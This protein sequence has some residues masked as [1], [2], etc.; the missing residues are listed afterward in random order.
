[1]RSRTERRGAGL[2]QARWGLREG[3]E[4]APTLTLDAGSPPC[5]A[6]AL[7]VLSPPLRVAAGA[8][9]AGSGASAAYHS[10]RGQQRGV[11]VA[12]SAAYHR[13]GAAA[14]GLKAAAARTK[15]RENKKP[16]DARESGAAAG[17]LSC[18]RSYFLTGSGSG[19]GTGTGRPPGFPVV[20]REISD[21][22]CAYE[23]P[24]SGSATPATARRAAHEP[25]RLTTRSTWLL[26][27]KPHA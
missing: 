17:L 14:W 1:M 23:Y 6:E 15:G 21:T 13:G 9:S 11:A 3:A 25:C 7:R 5:S 27:G 18:P 4:R 19:T 26:R 16:A 2:A 24:S 20:H 10:R 22:N 8:V 12:A